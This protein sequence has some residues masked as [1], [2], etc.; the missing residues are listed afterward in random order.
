M[1]IP[2]RNRREFRQAKPRAKERTYPSV[3]TTASRPRA[4]IG[5]AGRLPRPGPRETQV[6]SGAGGRVG[7]EDVV[8]PGR[9]TRLA[10]P[11]RVAAHRLQ[12]RRGGAARC[13]ASYS[14]DSRGSDMH[15]VI[16]PPAAITTVAPAACARAAHAG[17]DRRGAVQD[18]KPA[19]ALPLPRRQ[20]AGPPAAAPACR[21]R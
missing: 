20:H 16:G 12:G 11:D 6:G 5:N 7:D 14:D 3:H 2:N 9:R 1:T 13:S 15:K 18:L 17:R 21:T 8:G 10:V 19:P 4:H